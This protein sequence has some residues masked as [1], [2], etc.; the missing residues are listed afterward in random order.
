MKETISDKQANRI[1]VAM[2]V[3]G[4]PTADRPDNGIFNL[5]AARALSQS[6]DLTVLYLRAWKPN[7]RRVEIS[8]VD[9]IRGNNL[10]CS[11]DTERG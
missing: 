6:V 7:R 11:T 10:C 3:I 1:R 2:V 4:F 8:D 5:R 9:G